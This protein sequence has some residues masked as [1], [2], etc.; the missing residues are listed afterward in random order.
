[1]TKVQQIREK[2][3]EAKRLKVQQQMEA[4]EA[5]RV[6]QEKADKARDTEFLIDDLKQE[7]LEAKQ[8]C[9]DEEGMF[10]GAQE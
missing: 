1:M 10:I 9:F 3:Q 5:R 8:E 2:I 7:L 6:W 4:D